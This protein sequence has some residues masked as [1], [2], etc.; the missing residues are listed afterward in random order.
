MNIKI[1]FTGGGTAGHVYPGLS[2]AEKIKQLEPEVELLWIGS[3]KGME[4]EIVREAG[5]DFKGVPSGKL[6]RYF[7][8]KNFTDLF[9]IAGGLF[10][11]CSIIRKFKPD[12][13][14]SKG[15]FVSVTP[16]AAAG[17]MKIPVFSHE[18]DV[19]P[20]LATRIN[21][22]FSK[23]IFVSYEKTCDY[24][25]GG[26]AVLSGN[27]VRTA[28]FEADSQKGREII[29]AGDKKIIMIIGGS[30]G[31]LQVNKLIESIVG[32]L[33]EKYCIIHQSGKH[34]FAGEIPE[35]YKRFEYIKEELP[36][37]MAAAD[38]IISRA[39][40]SA[41]WEI[42][43]LG[44]P[45]ILIPLGTGASRGDQ[46]KNADIFKDAGASTVLEGNVTPQQLNKAIEDIMN[47]EEKKKQMSDAAVKLVNGNPAEFIAEYILGEVKKCR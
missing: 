43:A 44:K 33:S 1:I 32:S 2:V 47:N 7:S 46:Q 14:F 13:I 29:K 4:G 42:A 18:S 10:K 35:N 34:Q 30:L 25:S 8:F 22:R 24:I 5:I 41:L 45:S 23:K 16:V 39:G 12:L 20:G 36:H 37:F 17:I 27:P 15:G 11:S 40:A 26:K 6:R 31:A 9:R 38:L 21:S 3:N 19:T 28:I